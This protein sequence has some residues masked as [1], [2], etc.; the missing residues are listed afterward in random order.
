MKQDTEQL[1]ELGAV[2]VIGMAGE[3]SGASDIEQFWEN[4]IDGKSAARETAAAEARAQGISEEQLA[5]PGYVPWSMP[6]LDVDEFDHQLFGTP[7]PQ[8][9]LIDPQFRRFLQ[10]CWHSLENA[11]YNPR[12]LSD[13]EVAVIAGA[14]GNGYLMPGA[15][16]LA[17]ADNHA[18]ALQMMT[19]NGSDFLATR[20]AYQLGLSGPAMTVQTA[21]SSS[22]VAIINACQQL[23]CYHCDMAI[24]G[25]AG[26]TLPQSPGYVYQPGSILSP[27]G[28]CRPF[29]SEANGTLNGN[30]VAAVVLKRLE[31]ALEQGDHI[32]AVIRGGAINND[33]AARMDFMA[34]GVTGQSRAIRKAMELAELEPDQVQYIECHGTGTALG[35]PI[36]IEALNAVYKD[37]P[38][39][40]VGIGS[41]K[42]NIGHANAA[43][44]ITGLIKAVLAIEH[45]QLPATLNFKQANP[46]LR[47]EQTP[48]YVVD[49]LQPWPACDRR[50][51]AVS[52]LGFGGTN[53][54]LI[55]EQAPDITMKSDVSG[56]VV[57]PLSAMS[58]PQLARSRVALADWLSKTEPDSTRLHGLSATLISGRETFLQRSAVCGYD[59]E[60]LVNGLKETDA[61]AP[62]RK[63]QLIF[64]FTGQ[65]A[66]W[67]GMAHSLMQHNV[68]FRETVAACDSQLP[69]DTQLIPAVEFWQRPEAAVGDCAESAH[70]YQFCYQYALA[71]CWLAQG[72]QPDLLIAHSLG[73]YAAARIAGVFSLADAVWLVCQRGRCIDRH[74]GDDYTMLA[75]AS[76]A[77]IMQAKL[78]ARAEVAVVNG[79]AQ[80]VISG[81][82]IVLETLAEA[83]AGEGLRNRLLHTGHGFHSA[84][85]ETAL[86]PFRSCCDQIVFN[87]PTIPLI[88][89]MTGARVSRMPADYWV[90]QLRAQVRFDRVAQQLAA[91]GG[92]FVECGPQGVLGGLL[93]IHNNI[94]LRNHWSGDAALDWLESLAGLWQA[95][96]DPN[97]EELAGGPVLRQPAPGYPFARTR[98]WSDQARSRLNWRSRDDS[99]V[100]QTT[101]ESETGE[102]GDD[103]ITQWLRGLWR[104]HLG[105]GIQLHDKSD[106][107]T[108]GGNSLAAI[109]ICD[110][111]GKTLDVRISVT[112]FLQAR[113]FGAFVEMLLQQAEQSLESQEYIQ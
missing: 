104:E 68:R 84:Q 94:C 66:S 48:F 36:E 28:C 99:A 111:V 63:Q 6:I 56:P 53:A 85:M 11:G 71:R 67:P 69:A 93:R 34:P 25:G 40:S 74:C 75:V 12:A 102:S 60:N 47:L 20:V 23:Q 76:S 103:E 9:I 44:G 49:Q 92:D 77:E 58:Q 26:L 65:G 24:A 17:N 4:L 112:E 22:L 55:I 109:Q 89:S 98:L 31:D 30:A 13:R 113:T 10:I 19:G 97:W 15:D 61:P 106:F 45:G 88:S 3:F 2:A 62:P 82:R 101:L 37:L 64:G 14:N 16:E 90:D 110:Q 79:P 107:Y 80:T 50:R 108:L 42:S 5:H 105:A 1:E 73:E 87:P 18:R 81:P 29:D 43:A 35:D 51:A 39:G 78:P 8:A 59:T 86:A 21:C 83:L 41:V 52:S 32:R 72:I 38:G 70:Y 96:Y 100:P 46:E 54:H 27:D 33:G 7:A 57:L 91:D 95:G